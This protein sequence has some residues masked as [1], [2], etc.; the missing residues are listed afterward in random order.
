VLAYAELGG[1]LQLETVGT[2]TATRAHA[3]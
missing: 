3:A 2:V 1:Q